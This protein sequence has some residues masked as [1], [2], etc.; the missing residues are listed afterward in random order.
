MSGQSDGVENAEQD[1]GTAPGADGGSPAGVDPAENEPQSIEELQA[2]LAEA[3]ETA[4]DNWDKLLR[5]KAETENVRRRGTRDVENARRYGSER[6]A[7]EILAAVDSLEMGMQAAEGA[8][9]DAMRDGMR[10][11]L[12]LLTGGLERQGVECLDP[13]GELFDPQL[14]E[15]M[16]MQ[17]SDSAEPGSVVTVVQKGYSLNGRL[18]RPARVIVAAEP[19]SESE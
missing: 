14:H 10:A 17:A 7:T 9:P 3:R 8:T 16:S 1:A 5:A 4:A 12:K 13:E 11:T 6:L 18:L 15:A 2:A 19:P